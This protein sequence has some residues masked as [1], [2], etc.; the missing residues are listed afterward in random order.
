MR[1]HM[2]LLEVI[3]MVLIAF[4]ASQL[5]MTQVLAKDTVLGASMQPTLQ[6]HDRLFS[7][8]HKRVTRNAIVVIDAPDRKDAKLYIKRVIGLPGD[9]VRVHNEQ[10]YVNGQRQAQ[11]YLKTTFMRKEIKAW[12]QQTGKDTAGM[13][14]T[15]D[16]DLAS[17]KATH[18]PKVPAGEY[19]VMGDNRF[20]SHDGRAFGFVT[21]AQVKSVVVW[22][23]W[24]INQM[25]VFD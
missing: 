1:K 4:A 9:R 3:L 25:Q 12:G 22:R 21:A 10:L 8:R 14:F 16:F 17:N 13:Q 20:I 19:F 18:C 15:N 5:V 2:W 23:Y 7:L 24:P 6:N 11:P